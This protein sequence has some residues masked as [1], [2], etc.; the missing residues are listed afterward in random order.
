MEAK[1]MISIILPIYNSE[2]YLD[3]CLSSLARQ[4]YANLEILM[5]DDGSTD[6]SADICLAYAQRDI[7]F[8]YVRQENKGVSAAR[9]RGLDLA[10]GDYIGFCDSDDWAE[11]DMYA[12]LLDLITETG[13]DIAVISEISDFGHRAAPESAETILLDAESAIREMHRG[14]LFQG[15]LWNKLIRSELLAEIRFCE[16]VA[17]YEDM[18]LM[19]QVFHRANDIAFRDLPKYHYT[20]NPTSALRTSFKES[21]R[22]VQTA[23]REMLG[24]MECHYPHNVA[25][26]KKTLVL[27]N[28][29]LVD[30]LSA[31]G[32]LTRAEYRALRQLLRAHYTAEVKALSDRHLRL[33]MAFFFSGRLPYLAYLKIKQIYRRLRSRV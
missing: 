20:S 21:Y 13:T 33:H 12:C 5:I 3:R 23:C 17:I 29:T 26:A 16:N 15:Q 2:P 4:T 27:G 25:Y 1:V 6:G 19:W 11:P 8:R 10:S 9:N 22:T 32:L 28:Y 31:A 30:K 24:Y 7:R 14:E 18:L